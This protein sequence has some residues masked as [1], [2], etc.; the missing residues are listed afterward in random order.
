M[1]ELEQSG[2]LTMKRSQICENCAKTWLTANKVAEA[3]LVDRYVNYSYEQ[4]P[5][6]LVRDEW[7]SPR[8][9]ATSRLVTTKMSTELSIARLSY[10]TI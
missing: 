4:G 2:T 9:L 1:R 8:T 6:N 10:D 7:P 3:Q 5:S